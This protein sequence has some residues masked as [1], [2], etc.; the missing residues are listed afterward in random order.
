MG[1]SG[2]GCRIQGLAF[3]HVLER[4]SS[5]SRDDRVPGYQLK[6]SDSKP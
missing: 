6:H 5:D 2:L 3:R 4:S 1:G